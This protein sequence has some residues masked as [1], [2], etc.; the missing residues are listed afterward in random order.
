MWLL[1][2]PSPC[3]RTKQWSWLGD[4]LHRLISSAPSSYAVVCIVFVP[5]VSET[6]FGF[7]CN[8]V[9]FQVFQSVLYY[10]TLWEE[11]FKVKKIDKTKTIKN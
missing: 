3:F 4:V 11:K 5:D 6:L 2:R 8:N 1:V 10:G 9:M 7:A